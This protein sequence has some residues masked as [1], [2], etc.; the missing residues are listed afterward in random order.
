MSASFT[1]EV[2]KKFIK[3]PRPLKDRSLPLAEMDSPSKED[4]AAQHPLLEKSTSPRNLADSAAKSRQQLAPHPILV[5]IVLA[6]LAV[7]YGIGV[8]SIEWLQSTDHM[9]KLEKVKGFHDSF[10]GL[11]S[12]DSAAAHLRELVKEPHISGSPEDLAA[13]HYVMQKFRE[14]GIKTHMTSYDV[15]LSYP[16]KREL[17]MLAPVE[18]SPLLRESVKEEVPQS[19]SPKEVDTFLAYSKS[20]DVTGDVVYANYG[21]T[22]DF[23]E[24]ALLGVNVSGAIVI[25]RYGEIFRGDKVKN[26][27]DRGAIGC[28]IYSDPEEYAAN[29]TEGAY[30]NA[31]WLP[32]AGVQRGSAYTG[33]G[34]PLTPTWP[35]TAGAE[36]VPPSA[37]AHQLPAI[38]CLPLSWQDAVPILENLGGAPRPPTWHGALNLS[39]FALGRGPAR[40]HLKLEMNNSVATIHNVVGVIE[41]AAEP[42]RYVMLGNHRDAWVYGAADPNSGTAA[43]LEVARGYGSLLA[44]GWRPRRTILLLNW[45]AEEYG[46]IGSTEWVEDNADMLRHRGVA[47]FNVDSAVMRGGFFAAASP[48]L[49]D[50]VRDVTK[51][52]PEPDHPGKTIFDVW[53]GTEIQRLGGGGTDFAAMLQHVGVAATD[54]GMGQDYAVYHSVYDNYD[55]MTRF[56]DPGFHKHVACA[57]FWGL[58]G[59]NV[60]D[61]DVLPFDFRS[62]ASEL[63]KYGGQVDEALSENGAPPSVSSAPI[64]NAVAL[65]Q[66]TA[67]SVHST[68]EAL[69]GDLSRLGP[70]AG[71]RQRVLNDRL[72]LTERAF[73]EGEGLRGRPWYKHLVYGP[74]RDNNYGTLAFPGIQDAVADAKK[75]GGTDESWAVVQHEIYR[76]ARAIVRASKVLQGSLT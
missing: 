28:L 55:W 69:S 58:L 3:M 5:A 42:D 60:A 32:P 34:D 1:D 41:G 13:A 61:A 10:I 26:S 21:R 15:L 2:P 43:L 23:D 16:L 19:R 30:P 33:V 8:G 6:A 7:G 44:A 11:P 36:R 22:E 40:V 46:L 50:L 67:D 72:M 27:A 37:Y 70:G 39:S 48:Q 18:F 63:E 64:Y 12:N 25:A 29:M 17:H 53:N 14:Y 38:P 65:F 35:S 54:S 20:G 71:Q 68:P 59:L 9:Q 62:Y 52:V 51:V 45:D 31:E 74:P 24:L 49:D 73:L 66:R 47:Y 75:A 56:G 4:S 76:V 57:Q